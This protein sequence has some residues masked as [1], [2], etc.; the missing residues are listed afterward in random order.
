LTPKSEVRRSLEVASTV[1]F[2][3]SE[4]FLLDEMAPEMASPAFSTAPPSTDCI[5]K[6]VLIL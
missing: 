2:F 3:K 5:V 4:I 1:S 6:V